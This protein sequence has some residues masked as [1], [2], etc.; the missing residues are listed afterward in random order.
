MEVI[1]TFFGIIA[2]LT[3]KISIEK[4]LLNSLFNFNLKQK[5]I[6]LCIEY[7]KKLDYISSLDKEGK[8]NFIPYQA[9]K[10]FIDLKNN[11]N[12]I[13]FINRSSN[14]LD[15]MIIKRTD[16]GPMVYNSKLKE[17]N[18]SQK[19]NKNIGLFH[20]FNN[21]KKE[22]DKNTNLNEVSVNRSRINMIYKESYSNLNDFHQSNKKESPIKKRVRKSRSN[23]DTLQLKKELKDNKKRYWSNIDFNLL[24]YYCL[25]KVRNKSIEIELFHFGYNF[26]KSQMDI[27]NFINIFLLVQIVM[28]RQTDKK[29]NILSQTIELFIN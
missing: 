16:T 17:D 5:K 19:S 28:M 8:S 24:D 26:F 27:I 12:S 23:F 29:Q 20:M 2:L 4:K 1:Y 9:K 14:I 22:K 10:S 6:I 15:K 18:A 25:R 7:K 13:F 11:R 21:F 3:K